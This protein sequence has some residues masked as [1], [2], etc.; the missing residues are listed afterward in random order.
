M[1]SPVIFLGWTNALKD[2]KKSIDTLL[3][4][5]ERNRG[6]EFSQLRG[7]L[8]GL[9]FS[10]LCPYGVGQAVRIVGVVRMS[11]GVAFP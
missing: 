11:S 9:R 10:V 3:I 6:T 5:E 1:G 4:L 7:Y 8:Y 2:E